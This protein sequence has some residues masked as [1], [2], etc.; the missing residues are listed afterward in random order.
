M[1]NGVIAAS[2]LFHTRGNTVGLKLRLDVVNILHLRVRFDFL[3]FE[4]S[5]T[6]EEILS[7]LENPYFRKWIFE[8]CFSS[9]VSIVFQLPDLV[10]FLNQ[11][12]VL[13][14][15]ILKIFYDHK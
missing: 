14:P 3:E 5:T 13:T 2:R 15:F 4:I 12:G 9:I 10:L 8:S 1:I 6:R 7:C 11:Y